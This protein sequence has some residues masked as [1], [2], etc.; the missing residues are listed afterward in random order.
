MYNKYE[1]LEN[2]L[3][4]LENLEEAQK[5]IPVIKK[6]K[7][8]GEKDF[9][10]K[11]FNML[12]VL[13]KSDKREKNGAILYKCQCECG[14]IK[15]YTIGDVKKNTSCGCYRNSQARIDNIKKSMKCF[16]NTSIRI[17]EN[18]KKNSNNTSGVVGVSFCKSKNKWIAYIK[19]QRKQIAL[20]TFFTKEEAIQARLAGEKKY[21]KTLIDKYNSIIKQK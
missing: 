5:Y 1:E 6:K 20:G 3:K 7:V 8:I 15:F 10:G 11:K 9:I 12:T 19:I 13:E 2:I 21:Y 17:L 14:N 4:K 16:E 18:R